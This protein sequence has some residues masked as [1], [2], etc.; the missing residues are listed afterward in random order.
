MANASLG[1]L[2]I[3]LSL[4]AADLGASHMQKP[5]PPLEQAAT[6]VTAAAAPAAKACVAGATTPADSDSDLEVVVCAKPIAH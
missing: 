2:A 5:M 6:Q 3:S 1:T 4:W